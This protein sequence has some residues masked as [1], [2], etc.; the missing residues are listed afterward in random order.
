MT[1]MTTMT[2]TTMS[3]KRLWVDKTSGVECV[4]RRT[5]RATSGFSLQFVI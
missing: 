2:M 3:C 1:A 5:E 4:R